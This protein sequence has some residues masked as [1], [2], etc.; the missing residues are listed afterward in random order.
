MNH[1]R[2]NTTR[3]PGCSLWGTKPYNVHTFLY[4]YGLFLV[5]ALYYLDYVKGCQALEGC[6]PVGSTPQTRSAMAARARSSKTQR[7]REE[8]R[9]R[10]KLSAS[11]CQNPK[12]VTSVLF[13]KCYKIV[14]LFDLQMFALFCM[15]VSH[16]FRLVCHPAEN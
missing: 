1:F 9:D 16:A 5:H 12:N 13:T 8:A 14:R 2:F 6:N 3:S 10:S 15:D 11:T 7:P 4:L